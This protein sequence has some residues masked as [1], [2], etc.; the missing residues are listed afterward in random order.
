MAAKVKG[1]C[2]VRAGVPVKG[3]CAALH[4]W[5]WDCKKIECIPVIYIGNTMSS[6]SLRSRA[7]HGDAWKVI[8]YAPALDVSIN[9]TRKE[10]SV[11]VYG[12]VLVSGRF[13]EYFKT[14]RLVKIRMSGNEDYGNKAIMFREN[15]VSGDSFKY[16]LV[17]PSAV[18]V[19]TSPTRFTALHVL[20]RCVFGQYAQYHFD[21]VPYAHTEES[22]MVLLVDSRIVETRT[23]NNEIYWMAHDTGMW[24]ADDR[25]TFK[26][27]FHVQG[28]HLKVSD[29]LE[30]RST[31]PKEVL[32]HVMLRTILGLAVRR[33][34]KRRRA[35]LAIQRTWKHAVTNPAYAACR[36]RL[37]WEFEQMA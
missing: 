17:C 23:L 15:Q 18:R 26:T 32:R 36:K 11:L 22:S 31:I 12:R 10:Y 37:R 24:I 4:R 8:N 25:Y 34:M 14:H 7:L 6:Y 30:V 9:E 2:D 1:A 16:V 27:L 3:L 28:L 5:S 21:V 29:L 35:A 33:Y 13:E 20:A 19:I